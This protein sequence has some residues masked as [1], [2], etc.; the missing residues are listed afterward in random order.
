MYKQ[1]FLKDSLFLLS[2]CD[3]DVKMLQN[4]YVNSGYPKCKRGSSFLNKQVVL[5]LTVG[6]TDV[7]ENNQ[8]YSH[9]KSVHCAVSV[10]W[11]CNWSFQPENV[12]KF[13]LFQ[14]HHLKHRNSKYKTDCSLKW[15]QVT[16]KTTETTTAGGNVVVIMCFQR[17][18]LK[19]IIAM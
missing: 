7:Q 13:C 11:T 10:V 16:S 14:L 17:K 2:C 18:T 5:S 6:I 8:N 1:F 12:P 15:K 9:D 4:I 19:H 3:T